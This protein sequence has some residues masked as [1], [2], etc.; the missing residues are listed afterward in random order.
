MVPKR[1]RIRCA[2]NIQKLPGDSTRVVA[3]IFGEEEDLYGN[4]SSAYIRPPQAKAAYDLL[5]S[6]I[7][8]KL[9]KEFSK[10]GGAFPGS[11][12]VKFPDRP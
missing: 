12:P 9:R 8:D 11:P 6:K 1:H 2:F 3:D 10:K 4:W 7:S 5:F